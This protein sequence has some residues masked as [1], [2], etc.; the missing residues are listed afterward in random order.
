MECLTSIHLD[1]S[2]KAEVIRL[3][4]YSVTFI[5]ERSFF[6]SIETFFLFDLINSGVPWEAS[7]QSC[8]SGSPEPKP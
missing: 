5:V 7:L 8:G 2:S 1:G 4:S 6:G 3:D